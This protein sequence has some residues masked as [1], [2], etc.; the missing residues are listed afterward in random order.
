MQDYIDTFEELFTRLAWI[1]SETLEGLPV[2]MVLASFDDNNKSLFGK[3]IA[4]TQSH[5]DNSDWY[6][7]TSRLLKEHS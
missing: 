1:K 4:S 5:P 3:V 7:T 6:T 2:E